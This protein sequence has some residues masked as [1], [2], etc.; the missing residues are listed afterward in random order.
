MFSHWQ[1]MFPRNKKIHYSMQMENEI[2]EAFNPSLML[3]QLLHPKTSLNAHKQTISVLFIW[4]STDPMLS[5]S[6][7]NKSVSS[8]KTPHVW[9]SAMNSINGSLAQWRKFTLWSSTRYIRR[10]WNETKYE[11]NLRKVVVDFNEKTISELTFKIAVSQSTYLSLVI[12][13]L[14]YNIRLLRQNQ[15]IRWM[16]H[17]STQKTTIYSQSAITNHQTS[18]M[19]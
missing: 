14:R 11:A 17:L 13:W 7:W 2:L 12:S 3:W 5:N 9:C 6:I 1:K 15:G 8:I 16:C 19:L 4:C 18:H 10:G